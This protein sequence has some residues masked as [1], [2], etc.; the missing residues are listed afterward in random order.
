MIRG[1]EIVFSALALWEKLQGVSAHSL[2]ER[3]W[4]VGFDHP[5]LLF[6]VKDP[7]I[8]ALRPLN[9]DPFRHQLLIL[10]TLVEQLD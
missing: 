5:E 9:L 2:V 1:W 10:D 8:D 3:L 4:I 6:S 7:L